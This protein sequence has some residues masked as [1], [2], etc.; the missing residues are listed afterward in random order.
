MN[1]DEEAIKSIDA[2]VRVVEH[3]LINYECANQQERKIL[4]TY[5]IDRYLGDSEVA[6]MLPT[7]VL[8]RIKELFR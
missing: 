4:F 6:I 3:E 1:D 7:G 5:L 2:E 8:E